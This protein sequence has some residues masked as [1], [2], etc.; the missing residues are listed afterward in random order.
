[1][2]RLGIDPG[3]TDTGIAIVDSTPES[4]FYHWNVRTSPDDPMQ[5]RIHEICVTIG[6]ICLAHRTNDSIIELL[7]LGSRRGDRA[8]V[9]NMQA[10]RDLAILTGAIIRELQHNAVPVTLELPKVM[11]IGGKVVAPEMKKKIAVAIVETRYGVK[12]NHH[13]ADAALLCKEAET[14]EILEGWA[15]VRRT[16]GGNA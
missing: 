1:M 8:R 16:M 4:M 12:V 10:I 11:R 15:K 3:F 5:M 2:K 14:N 6:N 13:V 7:H 9:L